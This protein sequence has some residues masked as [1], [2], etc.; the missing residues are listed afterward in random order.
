MLPCHAVGKRTAEAARAAGFRTVTEGPGDATG[1]ARSIAAG[2]AGRKLAYICGH[3]RFPGFEDFLSSAGVT[4][5]PIETYDTVAVAY[6]D[7]TVRARLSDDPVAAVLLYSVKA[8]AYARGL[9][10]RP[11]LAPLFAN[12]RV[13]ALS[14]RIGTAFGPSAQ[15]APRPQ[16]DELLAL[17]DGRTRKSE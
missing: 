1:L 15:A 4:V 7:Q 16:E 12:A 11:A 2:L 14:Q 3:E 13:L 9:L 5:C 17:L 8:A 6:A 10:A